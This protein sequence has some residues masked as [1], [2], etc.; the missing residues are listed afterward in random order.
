MNCLRFP[1]YMQ[2]LSRDTASGHATKLSAAAAKFDSGSYD[3][4]GSFYAS[5]LVRAECIGSGWFSIVRPIRALP[6]RV[7]VRYR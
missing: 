1:D 3:A 2:I 4:V 7:P 5:Y 6:V